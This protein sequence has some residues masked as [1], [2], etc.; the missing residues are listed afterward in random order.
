MVAPTVEQFK[1]NPTWVKFLDS[2]GL[3]FKIWVGFAGI[4]GTAMGLFCAF[5]RLWTGGRN[6]FGEIVDYRDFWG[7]YLIGF[8]FPFIFIYY[9]WKILIKRQPLNFPKLSVVF[10]RHPP[11]TS[12]N[13]Y[14][15]SRRFKPATDLAP[16][17][18]KCS[19]VMR[20]RRGKYGSFWGCSNYP[21][22]RGTRK[23]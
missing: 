6:A 5:L 8:L 23:P 14:K 22:C 15:P 11:V 3:V 1:P 10:S 2:V 7:G 12:N 17:C 20:R 4:F 9:L 19:E 13:K 18:P 21:K 16:A